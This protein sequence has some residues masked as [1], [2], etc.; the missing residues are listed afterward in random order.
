MLRFRGIL[1][2][3][4]VCCMSVWLIGCAP[5]PTTG[6]SETAPTSTDQGSTDASSGS[7]TKVDTGSAGDTGSTTK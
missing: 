6:E 5:A 2:V 4:T 7:D 1:A 3:A